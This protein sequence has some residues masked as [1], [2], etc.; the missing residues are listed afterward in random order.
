M[1]LQWEK[2]VYRLS[3]ELWSSK[4]LSIITPL[5]IINVR[6]NFVTINLS[7]SVTATVSRHNVDFI[8]ILLGLVEQSLQL[9]TECLLAVS[10]GLKQILQ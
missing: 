8:S 1:F 2:S 3:V 6:D 7:S 10:I 9:T 5:S 4:T